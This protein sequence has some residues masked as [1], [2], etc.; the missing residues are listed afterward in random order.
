[1]GQ[2]VTYLGDATL[3][4]R[5]LAEIGQH[6]AADAIAKGSYGTHERR[7]LARLRDRLFPPVLERRAWRHR[8][9]PPNGCPCAV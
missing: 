6:E 8:S 3:K 9:Q 1:M 4:A 2:L 7:S 5:F